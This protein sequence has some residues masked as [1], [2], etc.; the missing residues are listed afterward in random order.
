[1]VGGKAY[2]IRYMGYIRYKRY[3]RDDTGVDVVVVT[4][5]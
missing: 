4:P 2:G 3:R 5:Q 1:M